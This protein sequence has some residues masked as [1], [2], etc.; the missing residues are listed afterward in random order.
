MSSLSSGGSI[1]VHHLVRSPRRINTLTASFDAP[2]YASVAPCQS[3]GLPFHAHH[4]CRKEMEQVDRERRL[5]GS[6][7]YIE[8]I[9][10]KQPVCSDANGLFSYIAN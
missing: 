9:L 2:T 6:L 10:A 4:A 7:G 3:H 8:I 1:P 5:P